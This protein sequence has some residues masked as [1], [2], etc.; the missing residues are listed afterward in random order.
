MKLLQKILSDYTNYIRKSGTIKSIE[1]IETGSYKVICTKEIETGSGAFVTIS[2][3]TNFNKSYE[4]SNVN[5]TE[6]SFLISE[7][8]DFATETT[9]NWKADAPYFYCDFVENIIKQLKQKDKSSQRNQRYPAIILFLPY[10]EN[11]SQIEVVQNEITSNVAIV[12]YTDRSLSTEAQFDNNFENVLMPI[13]NDLISEIERDRDRYFHRL[14]AEKINHT[15]EFVPYNNALTENQ[16]NLS[17]VVS[18][19]EMRNLTLNLSI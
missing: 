6:K 16:N 19:I 9:G 8:G 11:I 10:T 14:P 12:D 13:Y 7:S 15:F 17:S 2:A 5:N 1:K 3:T 18:A 4:I